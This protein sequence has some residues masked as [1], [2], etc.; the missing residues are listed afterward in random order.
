MFKGDLAQFAPADLLLFLC[1]MGKIGV[2]TVRGGGEILS[3]AFQRN[4][5]VEAHCEATDRIVLA[6]LE[7]SAEIAADNLQQLKRAQ[8]ETGLPLSRVLTE[9]SWLQ[10]PGT[11][12]ALRLGR[13]ETVLRLL[14]M[15]SGEFQFSEIAVDAVPLLPPCDG[16]GLVMDLTREV[17]EYR[18][19]LRGLGPGLHAV[20]TT[21]GARAAA[22]GAT[23]ATLTDEHLFLAA[24]GDGATVAALLAAVPLPRLAAAR[25]VRNAVDCGWIELTAT[26]PATGQPAKTVA[27]PGFFSHYRRALRR[28]LQTDDPQQRIRELLHF[29]QTHCKVSVL[30]VVQSGLLRRA[31]VYYRDPAGRLA[32]RDHREPRVDLG[33]DEVFQRVLSSGRPFLG[34]VFCSPLLDALE[35]EA[36]A[37]ACAVLP[38]G[39]FGGHDLLLYASTAARSPAV[40]PLS[41]LELLSWQVRRPE[42]EIPAAAAGPRIAGG[43]GA[44]PGDTPARGASDLGRM[45]AAIKDLPPMPQVIV[46]VLDLLGNPDCKLSELTAAIAHDPALVA[47]LI[48]V[49]NSS[50]YG[51]GQTCGSL[52]QAIVRLG[53]RT[54]RSVV[55]AA[56]TR[57]L[58]PNDG[59]QT[60]LLGRRLWRHAVES[61]LAARR[62]A[63][64]LRRGDPDEAFA[65]GVL[66]DLGKLIILL[67][68]PA[69]AAALYA[70]RS[71]AA[72]DSVASE[73]SRL[74]FAHTEVGERLLQSWGMPAELAACARWHHEPDAATTARD[75][76]QVVA[77]G[78]LLSHRL[79]DEATASADDPRAHRLAAITGSLGLD[80]SA[81]ADLL[82]LLALDLEQSDLFD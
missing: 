72:T 12:E 14:L 73:Q 52:N 33:G 47:R 60:G 54:T 64:F 53:T 42:G 69:D 5:L 38:L 3:L 41:C 66:H 15:E 2:L 57:T 27:D 10:A 6:R 29:A 19:S 25:A 68:L 32:A 80:D 55:V 51:G 24:T 61:G 31:T 75:L 49:S 28:L 18:E 37:A 16:P 56:S 50:L 62:V 8:E 35:A 59:S 17:D 9:M 11:N 34:E 70:E 22:G 46:R 48:K 81:R 7:R 78:N 71:A 30:M 43:V 26:P 45:V 77:C 58:F 44:S 82:G 20:R 67:N 65:A 79:G 36:P 40:G 1:H 21:A 13:R 76:V 74:G 63:E 39:P 4:L 23:V